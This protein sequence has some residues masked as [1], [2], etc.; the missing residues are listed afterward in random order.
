MLEQA[1]VAQPGSEKR[2]SAAT[3]ESIAACAGRACASGTL[4]VNFGMVDFTNLTLV[5]QRLPK[6]IRWNTGL[7]GIEAQPISIE[8]QPRKEAW[9]FTGE[10]TVVQDKIRNSADDV[11]NGLALKINCYGLFVA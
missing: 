9:P 7:E 5:V 2:G 1:F 8:G 6:A 4:G 11:L 3:M 10:R